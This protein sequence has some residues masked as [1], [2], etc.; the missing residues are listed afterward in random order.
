MAD[1]GLALC[2]ESQ[3]AL[4]P[5]LRLLVMSATL[6]LEPV[7]RLLGGSPVLRCEGRSFPV[8]M[9]YLP[10]PGT[11]GHAPRAAFEL[12]RHAANVAAHVLHTSAAAC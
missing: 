5:D 12:L 3:A 4:R 9:R 10:V 11:A 7:S 6:D 8:E 2:L 1:T